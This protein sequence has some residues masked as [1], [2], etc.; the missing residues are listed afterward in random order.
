M[1]F[2][3]KTLQEILKGKFWF[4]WFGLEPENGYFL[5]ALIWFSSIYKPMSYK[6]E[7]V[8]ATACLY[9]LTVSIWN[10]KIPHLSAIHHFESILAS[11]PKYY[12]YGKFSKISFSFLSMVLEWPP[13][14]TSEH[15]V[16]HC[17][18]SISARNVI[19]KKSNIILI[20][21]NTYLFSFPHLDSRN[22]VNLKQ[23][24]EKV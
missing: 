14:H 18:V 1:V 11:D 24:E 5:K 3:W 21:Y 17:I 22:T 10:M 2:L 8:L 19:F 12:L 20:W 23:S 13:S 7:K 4:G 6:P 9:G 15:Q 16:S